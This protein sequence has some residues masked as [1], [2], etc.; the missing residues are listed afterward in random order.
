M[1]P[2]VNKNME[3]ARPRAANDPRKSMR[4]GRKSGSTA[5]RLHVESCLK[6]YRS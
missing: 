4:F 5:G 6:I 1:K 3:S 2:L